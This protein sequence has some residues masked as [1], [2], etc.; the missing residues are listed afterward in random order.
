MAVYTAITSPGRSEA[1][2]RLTRKAGL[3][4][5]PAF[6]LSRVKRPGGTRRIGACRVC[7]ELSPHLR[8]FIYHPFGVDHIT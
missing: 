8:R 6:A 3:R 2:A 5:C 4:R 1:V 7:S